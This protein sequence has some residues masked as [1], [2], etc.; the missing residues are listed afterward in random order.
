MSDRLHLDIT[1]TLGD[2]ALTARGDIPLTG[3]TALE[4]ASGSGKTTLLRSIAGLEPSAKGMIRFGDVL[5]QGDGVFLPPQARR[6]GYVFQDARLFKHMDVGQNLAYGHKRAGAGP[7]VLERVIKALD[8]P[9]ML[10]R[11]VGSLSGG[12]SQRVAIGRALAMDPQLLLMDEPMS[13][14]DLARR[15][16]ILPYISRAVQALGCPA[17]YVS[18][19]R[20]ET[21][22]IAGQIMQI[23]DGQLHAPVTCETSLPYELRQTDFG[24]VICISGQETRLRVPETAD[25]TGFLRF[26]EAG[27]MLCADDPGHSTAAVSLPA[28]L[29]ELTHAAD[30]ICRLVLQGEGWRIVVTKQKSRC[31]FS[32]GMQLWVCIDELFMI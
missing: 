22:M 31:D 10:T 32:V 27:V 5:W 2:Y 20:R 7:E 16:E 1:L 4:G 23:A 8:L 17:I 28:K 21:S 11:R 14:L 18:H 13:G 19:E 26:N 9:D 6:I 25:Q 15:D 24:P 12:E 3:I 29:V 30:N